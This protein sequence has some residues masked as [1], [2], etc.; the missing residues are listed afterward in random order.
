MNLIQQHTSY[1]WHGVNKHGFIENGT[2]H[3]Q[4]VNELNEY[5]QNKHITMLSYQ[6]KTQYTLFATQRV[7]SKQITALTHELITLLKSDIHFHQAIHMTLNKHQHDSLQPILQKIDLDIA[8]G[9]SIANAFSNYPKIFDSFYLAA[10]LAGER[11]GNLQNALNHVYQYR[12]HQQQI[13]SKVIQALAYPSIVLFSSLLITL[14]LLV[15]VIPQFQQLFANSNAQLPFATRV[16]INLSSHIR[17]YGY[18]YLTTLCLSG[19]IFSK[20]RQRFNKLRQHCDAML[21][22]VPIYRGYYKLSRTTQWCR[23]MQTTL[24]AGLTLTDSL[25]HS[26]H[27]MQNIILK[28][29]IEQ[30]KQQVV[31][32]NTLAESVQQLSILNNQDKQLLATAEQTTKLPEMF[33]ILADQAQM[34][35]D[36][37]LN[38]LSKMLEPIIMMILAVIIGCIIIAMYLPVF[39]LGTV[40]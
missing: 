40:L 3:S 2:S 30:V 7:K 6:K 35:L 34:Q 37:M 33:G 24:L 5:L 28:A 16:I 27:A 17:Q 4:S 19:Y 29:Q 25:E 31:H 12:I 11:S 15:F 21:I 22:R 14:G 9:A 23:L 18:I 10:L 38:H 20:C 26:L 1:K 36:N 8:H 32:G 39:H 13:K